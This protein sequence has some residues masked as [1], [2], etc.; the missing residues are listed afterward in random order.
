MKQSVLF[1]LLGIICACGC[2]TTA[3]SSAKDLAA[4]IKADMQTTELDELVGTKGQVSVWSG[5]TGYVVYDLPSGKKLS[6]ACYSR[7]GLKTIFV[8]PDLYV[9]L[10]EKP[11]QQMKQ[12]RGIEQ[13][14]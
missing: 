11:G 5:G 13:P 10:Q 9:Y 8:H 12:I 14:N 7:D 2:I 1:L 6:V 4:R 3:H